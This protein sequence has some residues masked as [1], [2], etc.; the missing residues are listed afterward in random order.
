LIR[1][2][3]ILVASSL[4]FCGQPQK[5]EIT[6]KT[7]LYNDIQYLSLVDFAKSHGLKSTYYNSKE[8]QE[9]VFENKKMYFSPFSS[10]C[11]IDEK[12]Y[13]LTY[14]VILK[15]DVLHVPVL[16]FYQILESINLPV[17]L[18][19]KEKN[20]INVLTNIYNI[21][22]FFINN[23]TNGIS[24]VLNTTQEFEKQQISTSI[25]SGGWLNITILNSAIDSLGI[26]E[27]M[28]SYPIS[29]V[30]TLQLGQSSQISFLLNK[31]VDDIAVVTSPSSIE[32]LLSIEQ[33]NNVKKIQE[34]RKKWLIDTIVIDPGHGGKD[35]GALGLN[36]LKEKDITLDISKELGKLIERNL[37]MKV[38]YTRTEDVFIPLWKRT[39]IA[40]KSEADIFLS[41][42]AN[43]AK[44]HSSTKGF[45]TYLLRIGKT[46]AAVDAAHRENETI[47]LEEKTHEYIDFTDAKKIVA[48]MTQN[49]AVKSSEY[50][51][52]AIQTNLSKRLNSKDRGVK[53]AG[54]HV[55][56]GASM[57]NVLIEVGF[58]TNKEE[59]QN[60]SKY[61]YK[62]EIANGIF[63]AVV[64]F[65]NKY[66]RK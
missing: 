41:I 61:K 33:I 62:R 15:K 30:Q 47:K 6:L 66:E 37:G 42:H 21:K 52:Q 45:E 57:P 12:I 13:H 43:A 24:L 25:S 11:K 32:I 14:D 51:A 46:A 44:P 49:S 10:Y 17:Q 9:I 4:L 55:L 27:S 20:Q 5:S 56:V 16:P 34:L 36:T 7:I 38:I 39:Q 3:Y 1:F 48:S 22:N 28:L 40:N 60:L 26:K 2:F 19:G 53:Q 63:E 31:K 65:K 23:K 50:L 18:I 58:V 29:K 54:F 8:K 35:P 64:D 59:A